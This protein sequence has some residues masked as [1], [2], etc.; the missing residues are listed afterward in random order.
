M[1][2]FTKKFLVA[3][4]MIVFALIL[5]GPADNALAGNG[6]DSFCT[7]LGGKWNPANDT[8]TLKESDFSVSVWLGYLRDFCWGDF[9]PQLTVTVPATGPSY[10]TIVLT[11]YVEGFSA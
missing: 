11:F 7:Y 6:A 1:S 4:L 9:R 10:N 3:A 5:A 8:C 2:R